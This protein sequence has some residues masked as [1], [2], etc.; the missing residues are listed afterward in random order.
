MT[1]TNNGSLTPS[2]SETGEEKDPAV[3]SSKLKGPLGTR[4]LIPRRPFSPKEEREVTISF[5]YNK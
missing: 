4:H 2:V 3:G 1:G 5:V